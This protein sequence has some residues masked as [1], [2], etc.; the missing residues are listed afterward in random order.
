[1][2]GTHGGV[3]MPCEHVMEFWF[4]HDRESLKWVKGPLYARIEAASV[5]DGA[6]WSF[7]THIIGSIHIG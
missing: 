5:V 6:I 1:M 7:G 4:T 2:T 3:I